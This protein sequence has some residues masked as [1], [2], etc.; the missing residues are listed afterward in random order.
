MVMAGDKNCDTDENQ[1]GDQTAPPPSILPH[2]PLFDPIKTPADLVP[3][4]AGASC[5]LGHNLTFSSINRSL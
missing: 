5:F 1:R 2:Q 4:I 3:L